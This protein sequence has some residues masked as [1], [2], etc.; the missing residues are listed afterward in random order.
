MDTYRSTVVVIPTRNRAELAANAI[1]SALAQD[2][3]ALAAVL[4]SDN[5]SDEAEAARLK[6]FCE[7]LD[8][9]RVTYVRPREPLPMSPHWDW[10]AGRAL[11]LYGASHVTFL[12]DRMILRSGALERLA[13]VSTLNP[14][15]VVS[16]THDRVADDGTPVRLHQ[17]A[18]SGKLYEA[19]SARLLGAVARSLPCEVLP[20]LLNCH[21]PRELLL[22]LR[23][24]YGSVC[25][26]IAPDFS[27]CFRTLAAEESVLFLDEALI[28]HYALERSNGASFVRGEVTR[29][30]ADF[31]KGL[32][33]GGDYFAAPIPGILTVHNAIIHEYCFASG[34]AGGAKFPPV[35]EERYLLAIE[36]ELGQIVNP[37]A[38]RAVEEHLAERRCARGETTAQRDETAAQDAAA[39]QDEPLWR[40][41]LSPS[42]VWGRV[43][44]ALAGRRNGAADA[45]E[46]GAVA[47]MFAEVGEAL[48]YARAARGPKVA[49]STFA[50]PLGLREVASRPEGASASSAVGGAG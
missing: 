49:E 50:A 5:S 20:R 29:D 37:E 24:R 33:A 41:L 30:S 2:G 27:F 31:M 48:E 44:R 21:V 46:G 4:V 9:A 7:E 1:R 11:E 43:S 47:P 19:D 38:R 35:D 22:S 3:R 6:A 18:W 39:V 10:A 17:N 8:D 13:A 15:K 34:E 45:A 26:S 32:R 42:R 36:S 40:K 12:T 14:E 25:G 16:Y 23:A 28:F